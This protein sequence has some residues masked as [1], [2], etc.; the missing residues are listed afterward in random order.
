LTGTPDRVALIVEQTAYL[1]YREDIV[2]LVIAAI[3]ATLD[4]F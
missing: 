3:A 1:S 4:G 2:P